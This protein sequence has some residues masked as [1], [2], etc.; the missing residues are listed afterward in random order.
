[1]QL[2]IIT[3]V[4]DLA[5]PGY[6]RFLTSCEV[7]GI[8]PITWLWP[9]KF[10]RGCVAKAMCLKENIGTLEGLALYTDSYDAILAGSSAELLERYYQ[11]ASPTHPVI[12]A[13]EKNCY[14]SPYLRP[15]Y[16][17]SE[18]P[19]RYL[20]AGGFIGPVE[21]LQRMLTAN[22]DFWLNDQ[23]EFSK[24]Y[25]EGQSGIGLDTTCQLFQTL[26]YSL[27]DVHY[28]EDGPQNS[29]TNS[30]PLVMHANGRESMTT[31]TQW[32]ERRISQ[33]I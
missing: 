28:T 16:A 14:P 21:Y 23:F 32:L 12:F 20:N 7:F 25:L 26:A 27:E 31:A 29:I 4:T 10:D 13:A 30:N 1:M 9:R 2:N 22:L 5:H 3:V 33:R 24:L 8:Q 6:R 11:L 19:W 18:S 17:T 15:Y